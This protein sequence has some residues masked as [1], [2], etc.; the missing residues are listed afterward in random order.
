MTST[1]RLSWFACLALIT[2][3]ANTAWAGEVKQRSIMGWVEF[4]ELQPWGF[5]SKAKLD[6]GAKTSS[7]HAENIERFERDGEDWARF[8]FVFKESKHSKQRRVKLQ[9]PVIRTVKIKRH[10]SNKTQIRPVVE[11]DICLNNSIHSAEFS[12]IDRSR[13]IYPVLLGRSL[14]REAA[15]VD[16]GSTFLAQEHC[17]VGKAKK[18]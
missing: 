15:I 11:L 16:P 8:E 10:K 5:K 13:F 1:A 6:T 9:A 14:L 7:L 12:L 4:V 18:S 2:A 17:K 3:L